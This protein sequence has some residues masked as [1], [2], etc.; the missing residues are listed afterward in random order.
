[1]S[2]WVSLKDLM[3]NP[4][5]YGVKD[6]RKLEIAYIPDKKSITLIQEITGYSEAQKLET[7]TD[8]HKYYPVI[9]KGKVYLVSNTV[10]RKKVV[11]IG[12]TGYENGPKA[13]QEHAETY[14][15]EKL[16]AKGETWNEA[17]IGILDIL[18]KFLRRIG[19]CY[20]TAIQSSGD[21][22]FG[23][24]RV[25]SSGVNHSTLYYYGSGSAFSATISRAVRPLVSLLSNI[26]VDIKKLDGTPLSLRLPA[27]QSEEQ[28]AIKSGDA[29]IA[30]NDLLTQLEANMSEMSRRIQQLTA[31]MQETAQLIEKIKTQSLT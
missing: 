29:T 3:E 28:M 10:T 19:E 4:S 22:Y 16:G 20:W 21:C 13:L 6:P 18:P 23:L 11:L 7:E 8:G 17:T 15:N 24:Q 31:Q 27:E 12:K 26:Q 25:Y 14:G 5:K 2:K 9:Y 1:M 30:E